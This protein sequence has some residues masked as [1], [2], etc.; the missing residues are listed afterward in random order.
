MRDYLGVNSGRQV[1]SSLIRAAFSSVAD[2]AIIPMQDY[3]ELDE[4]ARINI[5]STLGGN[6][7]WRMEGDELTDEL[8]ERMHDYA[9]I[10]PN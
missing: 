8:C 4:S 1:V 3:L 5:P 7:Q 2:T 10:F 9:K 6:W